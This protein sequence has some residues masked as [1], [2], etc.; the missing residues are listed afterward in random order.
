MLTIPS[1]KCISLTNPTFNPDF[2][3][4]TVVR[5][6]PKVFPTNLNRFYTAKSGLKPS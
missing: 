4:E 3:V 1:A 6:F 5:F 2:S